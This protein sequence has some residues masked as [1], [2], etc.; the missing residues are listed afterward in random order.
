MREDPASGRIGGGTSRSRG[1]PAFARRRTRAV[2]L[3]RLMLYYLVVAAVMG[4][5]AW[6][7]PLVQNAFLAPIDVPAISQGDALIRGT[8]L[9]PTGT[10]PGLSFERTL[11]RVLTTFLVVTGALVLALPVAWVYMHTKRL[12]YDASLVQSVIILPVV[13]AGILMV[14]KASLALAFAL[15]GIVSAVRFRNTLKDPKDLIY[16]FLAIGLGIASGVQALDI[17]FVLSLA[18]NLTVLGLWTF[19][20]GSIY[21]RE[22]GPRGILSMGD[23]RLL[24]AQTPQARSSLR[25]RLKESAGEMDVDGALLVHTGDPEPARHAVELS[26]SM[27]AKEWKLVDTVPGQHGLATLQF[28]LELKKKATVVDL[29]GELDERWPSQVVAAEFVP[30]QAGVAK[31]EQESG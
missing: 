18:F 24:V 6:F 4:A 7:I 15:T 9:A 5:L 30:F 25:A 1:N 12:R 27:T 22:A 20:V 31:A 29:L 14:V 3:A 8:Q 17:S 16:I 28:L 19:N 26:L 23:Q 2:P 10:A 13:V 21:S 11:E